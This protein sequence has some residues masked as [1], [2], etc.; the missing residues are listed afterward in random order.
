VLAVVISLLIIPTESIIINRMVVANSFNLIDTLPALILPFLST[1]FYIF[2]FFQH[3]RSMPK[4]LVEAAILDGS[5]YFRIYWQIMLPLSKPVIAT[6]AILAF[7]KRWSDLAWP[8]VVTRSD[9][10]KVLP[11]ALQSFYSD[12]GND[13]GPLFSLGTLM[14]IP[15]L[16]VFF[17]FQR[18]FI[19]SIAHSGGKG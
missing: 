1:P 3:F 19:A 10:I 14:T 6:V 8:M 11:L 18:Q 5:G 9:D 12:Q 2:L 16:I 4:D 17:I 15:V 7:V 13:W